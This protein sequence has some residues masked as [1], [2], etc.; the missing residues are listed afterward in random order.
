MFELKYIAHT[1]VSDLGFLYFINW[2]LIFKL[3]VST[4]D[5]FTTEQL[6]WAT[7][8]Q[9]EFL[10]SP[11]SSFQVSLKNCVFILICYISGSGVT[12]PTLAPNSF[13]LFAPLSKPI[14]KL[15]AVYLFDQQGPLVNTVSKTIGW[16]ASLLQE[17]L[18]CPSLKNKACQ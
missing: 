17:S 11:Q 2:G 13:S 16:K 10:H 9:V 5:H 12:G 8:S 18:V 6:T 4:V 7:S 15:P 3:F 14:L 1:A